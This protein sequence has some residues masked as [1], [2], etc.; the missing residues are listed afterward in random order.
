MSKRTNLMSGSRCAHFEAK[1][2]IRNWI[3][4]ACGWRLVAAN[5]EAEYIE[6]IGKCSPIDET[7]NRNANA[8]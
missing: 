6:A 3:G 7:N 4:P 8:F 1:R 2:S 5:Y